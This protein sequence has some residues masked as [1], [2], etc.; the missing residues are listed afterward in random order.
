M[1]VLDWMDD[2]AWA[3][4]E[5]AFGRTRAAPDR[6]CVTRGDGECISKVPCMHS[7]RVTVDDAE[8]R[9]P[10]TYTSGRIVA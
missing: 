1:E 2:A 5:A 8:F 6:D 3:V 4:W 7:P 9:T 10:R